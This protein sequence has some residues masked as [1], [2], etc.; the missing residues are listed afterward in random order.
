MFAC[1]NVF[2]VGTCEV[3]LDEGN[4]CKFG[5]LFSSTKWYYDIR[6][7]RCLEFVFTGCGGNNNNFETY[8]DCREWCPIECDECENPCEYPKRDENGCPT[9]ECLSKYFDFFPTLLTV[10][11]I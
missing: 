8:Y 7:G 3:D 10:M 5:D 9:C 1:L 11:V 2:S 4:P 6:V